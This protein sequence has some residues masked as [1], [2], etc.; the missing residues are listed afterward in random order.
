M[1]K[2]HGAR[3]Q[4]R[5]AKQKA[6]SAAK[7]SSL[8]RRNSTD[9]TIRL[10][11]AEKWLIVKALV[12]A[13]LWDR[14]IGYLLIARQESE[15]RLIMAVFL[16]DVYCLGV[17]NAFWRAGT[18]E[19]LEDLIRQTEKVQMMAAITPSCLA[20]IVK[21]AVEY[22]QSFGFP[23]HPDYDHAALLLD[24]LDPSTCPNQFAFGRDGKP[25]YIQGP[26]ESFALAT[27]ISQ[28]IQEADGHYLVAIPDVG[29][30]EFPT[31]EG[32]FDELDSLD[33]DDSADEG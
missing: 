4:K 33:D 31:T 18:H 24:G 8:L 19:D 13:V 9:P 3:Q 16:V 6:K 14:G 21:G 2:N 27:A 29:S 23:P 20:K 15:G 10:R 30:Q 22:A 32:A 1:A 26:N 11:G 17:K 5:V 7:R 28:R 25:F 12:S